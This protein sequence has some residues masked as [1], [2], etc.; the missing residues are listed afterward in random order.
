MNYNLPAQPPILSD[1]NKLSYGIKISPLH[2]AL[3]GVSLS[4]VVDS[5]PK[6]QEL[7]G[8]HFVVFDPPGTT[9]HDRSK[10]VL[11]E[12]TWTNPM[13]AGWD[14]RIRYFQGL[15]KIVTGEDITVIG[16]P[17]TTTRLAR[18]I[19]FWKH[20]TD[21]NHFSSKEIAKI[22][23]ND[24]SPYAERRARIL[25]KLKVEKVSGNAM[26]WGAVVLA[27]D[28]QF[29]IEHGV[30][31][32]TDLTFIDPATLHNGK[33]QQKMRSGFVKTLPN[34]HKAVLG[35]NIPAFITAQNARYSDLPRQ[36]GGSLVGFIGDLFV[37]E[38]R[39]QKK[40]MAAGGFV[41]AMQK[42]SET[43]HKSNPDKIIPTVLATG[44]QSGIVDF[45]QAIVDEL[46][47]LPN[48]DFNFILNQPFG[49]AITNDV[50]NVSIIGAENFKRGMKLPQ[51][52]SCPIPPPVLSTREI[53][54]QRARY[55]QN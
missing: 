44:D 34:Y 30:A 51:N 55:L 11:E 1:E 17:S 12:F 20:K 3:A 8:T 46:S 7:D 26:S 38:V 49:H 16:M 15:I 43:L 25:K 29:F 28:A 52:D 36:F 9:N 39:A 54:Q 2:T 10:V 53:L 6:L 23:E 45:D 22:E 18:G 21:M 24:L 37:P 48:L 27:A 42:L 33:T 19:P 35:T 5:M 4:Q 14:R 41:P 13:S 40:A 31:D 50:P 32:V 47:I